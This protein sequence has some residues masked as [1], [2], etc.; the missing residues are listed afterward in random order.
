MDLPL[1]KRFIPRRA[2]IL[3]HTL[4]QRENHMEQAAPKAKAPNP[5][6]IVCPECKGA[7]FVRSARCRAC[8][9]SGKIEAQR[10]E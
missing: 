2:V 10:A 6:R 7:Q 8:K 9:G 3:L 4:F 5:M 1:P